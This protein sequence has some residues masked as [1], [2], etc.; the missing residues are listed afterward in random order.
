[1][2]GL[3]GLALAPLALGGALLLRRAWT[4]ADARRPWLIVGGWVLLAVAVAASV[5]LLGAARG[6]SIVLALA[7]TV[8]LAV[9]AAGVELR[10]ARRKARPQVLGELALE[11]SDRRRVAWRGWLRGFLA[12]PLGGAAAMAVGLAVAVCFP[13]E[14][15]TRLIVGGM[16]VP[17]LWA[18]GMAWTLSD[19]K[20]L[21]ALAVLV[22]VTVAGFGAVFL[23]GSL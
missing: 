1:M 10:E 17:F 8:A 12:G 18:G 14:V 20:I 3:G 19:D 15:K 2:I 23:K 22:G 11:P 6:P 5:P 7:S 16:L 21:R 13:A 9:V 4:H